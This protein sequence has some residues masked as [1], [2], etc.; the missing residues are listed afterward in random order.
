MVKKIQLNDEQWKT[1]QS[2]RE[3]P[4][5]RCPTESI[6]VSSRLKSN[7][8]VASDREG[9]HFLTALGLGRLSQGR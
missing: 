8:L 4:A 5:K 7:G 9:R 6:K 3:A 2:L 1:L